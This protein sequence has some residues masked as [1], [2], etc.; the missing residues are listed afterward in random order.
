MRWSGVLGGCGA[1]L[2]LAG[3]AEPMPQRIVSI[4]LCTDQLLLALAA[5]KQILSLSHLS[6]D[7]DLSPVAALAQDFAVNHGQGE[8]ILL[9][10][11]DLV[12]S[13]AFSPQATRQLLQRQ[14]RV[15]FDLPLA[16]SLAETITYMRSFAKRIGQDAQGEVMSQQLEK[17]IQ[18]AQAPPA[19]PRLRALYLDRRGIVAGRGTLMDDLLR[20]AG[21][22][23]AAAQ[24]GIEGWAMLDVERILALQPQVLIVHEPVSIV[25]DQGSALLQ[26]PALMLAVPEMMR[27]RVPR[28]STLCPAPALGQALMLLAAARG[29]FLGIDA[30]SL[31]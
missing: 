31:R 18:D 24:Q 16:S 27:V 7:A 4:N 10:K 13:G 5:P 19:A 8:E 30:H 22:D 25:P 9:L 26:H 11:P 14:G 28:A 23:N 20:V 2:A 1:L 15:V 12:V 21:F 29:R 17:Q 6:R 3:A